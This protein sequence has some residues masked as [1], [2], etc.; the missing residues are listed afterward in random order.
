[1]LG[2]QLTS[3][4]E[5]L[6]VRR[7]VREFCRLVALR[8]R[9]TGTP[10]PSVPA[11]LAERGEGG[12]SKVLLLSRLGVRVTM[13]LI[14]L[15]GVRE[16]AVPVEGAGVVSEELLVLLAVVV[17]ARVLGV[18][19]AVLAWAL[20]AAGV[21]VP[22]VRVPALLERAGERGGVVEGVPVE[23]ELDAGERLAESEAVR[24]TRPKS[25]ERE[26]HEGEMNEHVKLVIS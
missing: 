6:G 18:S 23:G 1:M 11:E 26:T 24:L 9:A 19:E 15:L 20:V 25:A 22:L 12:G 7:I 21:C 2:S 17:L 10:P 5:P 8:R 16:T 3:K 14:V 4:R 13:T